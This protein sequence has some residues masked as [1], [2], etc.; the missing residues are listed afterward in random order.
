[1]SIPIHPTT[2]PLLLGIRM[3]FCFCFCFANKDYLCLFLDS[4]YMCCVCSVTTPWIIARQA[5]L[6]MEFSRQEYWSGLL[7]P[8]PGDFPDQGSNLRL[9]CLL[10]WEADC[11][12]LCFLEAYMR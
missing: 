10:P 12:P 5:P 2:T 11:L 3:F 9:L 8:S 6:S 1:M 4:T 7:F